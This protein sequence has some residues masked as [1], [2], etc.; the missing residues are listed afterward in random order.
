MTPPPIRPPA[1]SRRHLVVSG[2]N[3][4][5]PPL[6]GFAPYVDP[7][8]REAFERYWRA[9]PSAPLAEAAAKGDHDAL[10]DFLAAFMRATGG[11]PEQARAF[12]ERALE[13]TL[14]LFDSDVRKRHLDAEGIVGEVIF[15]DGFVENQP[16]WSDIMEGHGQ[17]FG[18][19]P[20]PFELQLAGAR[21]Y[22]RWLAAFC[23]EDPVRRAG[24][25]QLPAAYDVSALVEEVRRGRAAGLRGGVLIPPLEPGLPGYHDP[26]YDPLWAAASELGLPISVHGGNA[27]AP[28]GP[29]AYGASEPLAS[30][31]HFT[32]STFFD[33]RPLWFFLW[34]GVFDRHPKLRL[35]FAEALAHWV[36]QE[37]LRLD[38]MVDMWNARSLR[39]RLSRKPS[40]YWR[41]HCAITA[42][43]VSRGEVELRHAIGLE[44]LLWGSDFPH[45]EGT[46]PITPTCLRHAFHD[47]AEDEAARVLGE[48]ALRL[49]DFDADALRARADRIG[50]LAADV[51]RPPDRRPSD[52]VGMGLR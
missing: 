44:N 2:D 52:Y 51:I 37:L 4:A 1:S 33:R 45:P 25:I 19:R 34:G 40:E 6:P 46:W 41:D 21:A 11:T 5:G 24:V 9:R 39:D 14:G 35:I 13:A 26:C 28:D 17:L 16:P 49:Y 23:A 12:A 36:P 27:R 47:V 38:E 20:W 30:F 3:H 42:T 22:N 48:N 8:H 10:A 32:E 15:G 31:F 7:A 18:G 50:P 29:D 43:F